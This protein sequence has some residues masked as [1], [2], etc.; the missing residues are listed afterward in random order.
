MVLKKLNIFLLIFLLSCAQCWAEKIY[1]KDGETANVEITSRNKDT[2]W[3]KHGSGSTGMDVKNIIKIENDN[4]LLSKYDVAN[5]KEQAQGFIK[6]KKY[7]EA[8]EVCGVLLSSFPEDVEVRYLRAM[9]NQ[10]IG[11]AGKAAE[12]YEFLVH[13][14]SAGGEIF[15]NLGVIYAKQKKYAQAEAMFNEALKD[16]PA[17]PEFHN[18]SAELF[19]ALK[20]F[21]RAIGEYKLV[22]EFEPGNTLALYNLGIAYKSKGDYTSAREQWEKILK[23]QPE[24][25]GA[26]KALGYLK[27]E[28]R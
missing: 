26:K 18:N 6:G 17:R 8:A 24:D 11:D 27:K 9:L 5:L 13:H 2:I 21:D 3:V 25:A 4:G 23:L 1:S 12:D 10:K 22:L 15:N 28:G 16:M 7:S 19:M 20:D 14:K